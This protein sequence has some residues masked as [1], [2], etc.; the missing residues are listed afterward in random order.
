M[1]H[2]ELV[3]EIGGAMANAQC[4]K[5]GAHYLNADGITLLSLCSF[6]F[7]SGEKCISIAVL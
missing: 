5:A 7:R 1:Q 4:L 2:C 3:S 6:R